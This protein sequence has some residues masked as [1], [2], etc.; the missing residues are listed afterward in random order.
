MAVNQRRAMLLV[1]GALFLISL[2]GGIVSLQIQSRAFNDLYNQIGRQ[3]SAVALQSVS[4]DMLACDLEGVKESLV[5]LTDDEL[6]LTASIISPDGTI[7]ASDK[8]E[9]IGERIPPGHVLETLS[10]AETYIVAEERGT[11]TILHV[12]QPILNA[13]DCYG[14]HDSSIRVLAAIDMEIDRSVVDQARMTQ[15]VSMLIIVSVTVALLGLSIYFILHRAVVRPLSTLI[16]ELE[17]KGEEKD[18]LYAT[19]RLASLG[20]MTAGIAH[21]VNNPLAAVLLY[22]E[23]VSREEL[24]PAVRQDLKVIR[25]EAKRATG[26]MKDLLTYSRRAQPVTRRINIRKTLG[27]VIG[28]RRYQQRVRNITLTVEQ[29][30]G[31]LPV[32][33]N[34]AQLTQVFMN[35]IVNAEEALDG[36]D[37]K[38]IVIRTEADG[39]WARI[40]IAD[41]GTGIPE[42]N[43]VEVFAPFFSTKATGQGTGLGLAICHGIVTAHGGHLRAGNNDMGGAT[44]TMELPLA[45]KTK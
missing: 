12:S 2:V 13:P 33:A 19:D 9:T 42:K 38:R 15:T 39:E 27:K 21:E 4:H 29:D 28:M 10:T 23:L 35:L 3:V 34:A 8:P 5:D 25:S 17:S 44:F 24:P 1:M 26:I 22:S 20:E 18:R 43:L 6:I 31:P 40:S 37:N 7:W 32:R 30:D 36:S 16:E 11:G 14:C 45:D 41:S